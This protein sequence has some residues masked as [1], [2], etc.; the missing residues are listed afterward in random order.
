M[1]DVE[2]TKYTGMLLTR[3]T[4]N[5]LP[6]IFNVTLAP[7]PKEVTANGGLSKIITGGVE[8]APEE[9]IHYGYDKSKVSDVDHDNVELKDLEKIAEPILNNINELLDILSTDLE[10]KK[11]FNRYSLSMKIGEENLKDKVNRYLEPSL[12]Q[13]ISDQSRNNDANDI[14]EETPFFWALRDMFYRLSKEII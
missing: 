2:L 14:V 13:I 12:R 4:D 1:D 11:F 8:I 7:N 5:K 9:I 3:F 6:D 10:L